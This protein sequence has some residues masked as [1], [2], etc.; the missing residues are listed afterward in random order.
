MRRW[1]VTQGWGRGVHIKTALRAVSCGGPAWSEEGAIPRKCRGR[2]GCREEPSNEQGHL[3]IGGDWE[4]C[5]CLRVFKKLTLP[6]N[7]LEI[8]WCLRHPDSLPNW[9]LEEVTRPDRMGA[10]KGAS[11]WSCPTARQALDEGAF[12]ATQVLTRN[13]APKRKNSLF[14]GWS[15]AGELVYSPFF[16]VPLHFPSKVG[17]F[18]PKVG[19]ALEGLAWKPLRVWTP[20]FLVSKPNAEKTKM[21]PG[22]LDRT[23]S[24]L[25]ITIFIYFYRQV[26]HTLFYLLQSHWPS[27]RLSLATI[28]IH[29]VLFFMPGYRELFIYIII[30]S[31]W[32]R[33]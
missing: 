4:F 22:G 32:I 15:C 29:P 2:I 33:S 3:C 16:P 9:S 7:H 17:L 20:Y 24:D 26:F 12:S 18:N 25:W 31:H 23:S 19:M 21:L 8:P 5:A 28:R 27:G 1:A 13:Q 14:S 11:E 30:S 10:L 6:W